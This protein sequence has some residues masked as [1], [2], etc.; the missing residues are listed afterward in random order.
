M[1]ILLNI[2]LLGDIM[3]KDIY[4]RAKPQIIFFIIYTVVFVVFDLT[5]PVTLPFIIGLLTALLLQPIFTFM[6]KKLRFKRSFAAIIATAIL[7][8]AIFGLLV[9]LVI[10]LINESVELIIKISRADTATII[11]PIFDIVGKVFSYFDHID[12]Q[13][14]EEHKDEL[15]SVA[16]GGMAILSNLLSWIIRLFTSIPKILTMVIVTIFSTYY[17]T[18]EIKT[19]KNFIRVFLYA[20]GG[21]DLEKAYTQ[22][23]KLISKFIRS[24]MI[25]YGA[26]FVESVIVFWAL[27]IK[28]PLLIGFITGIA[29]IVPILGP[30]TI[31]LPLAA[32]QFFMG[33]TFACWGLVIAWAIVTVI[34]EIIEPKIIAQSIQIHPLLILAALYASLVT[35]SISVLLYL[36]VLFVLYQILIK[37][38]ILHPIL[39]KKEK[40]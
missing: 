18:K 15:I 38:D 35:R 28:Y 40:S 29:D 3:I 20:E 16:G 5:L 21:S 6:R 37:V 39:P 17:F 25:V 2:K 11:K 1:G 31:Y 19:I 7:F 23:T 33:N 36:I 8:A 26:T 32:L 14:L 4:I 12:A 9:W 27:G 22:G 30:G 13:F 34:R 10:T 24:Y